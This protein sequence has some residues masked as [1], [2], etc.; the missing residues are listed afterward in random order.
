MGYR[1]VPEC[2]HALESRTCQLLS[3]FLPYFQDY[4]FFLLP[5]QRDETTSPL[6]IL[7]GKMRESQT[8]KGRDCHVPFFCPHFYH[9][10]RWL[11]V[12][13]QREGKCFHVFGG[14][15]PHTFFVK[16]DWSMFFS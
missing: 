6:Y 10:F 4:G 3:F 7:E 15:S 16:R 9:A 13:L 1:F 5:W 11:L 2:N 12:Y 8:A 14:R